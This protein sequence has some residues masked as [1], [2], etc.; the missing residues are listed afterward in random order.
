M[1]YING[2]LKEH[3]KTSFR[4]KKKIS[5]FRVTNCYVFA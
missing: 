1:R 2:D 3:T 4:Q 5:A